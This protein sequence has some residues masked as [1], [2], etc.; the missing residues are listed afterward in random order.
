MCIAYGRYVGAL[1]HLAEWVSF[2]SPETLDDDGRASLDRIRA[3]LAELMVLLDDTWREQ[4][5]TRMFEGAEPT[6]RLIF[7]IG[8]ERSEG[9]VGETAPKRPGPLDVN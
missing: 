3:G 2:V 5:T 7:V 1:R 8:F 6:L 9:E 4:W